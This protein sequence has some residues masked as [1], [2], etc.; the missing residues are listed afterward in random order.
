MTD[1]DFRVNLTDLL[2][3]RRGE[4]TS[5]MGQISYGFWASTVDPCFT[6]SGPSER[7][8]RPESGVHRTA[9]IQAY[10]SGLGG[11]LLCEQ[12]DS[13]RV[14]F[15]KGAYLDGERMIPSTSNSAAF[16]DSPRSSMAGIRPL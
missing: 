7:A 16:S 5:D 11:R 3:T 10:G 9:A 14:Y 8:P 2:T 1:F 12:Q 6:A 15:S 4:T 13:Q